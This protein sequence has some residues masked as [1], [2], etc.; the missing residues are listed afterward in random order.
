MTSIAV[1]VKEILGEINS[2]SVQHAIKPDDNLFE[3]GIL[4]SL[5]MV[6]FIVAVENRF[7]IKIANRDINY[8][9]FTTIGEI[10]KFLS[11]RVSK[12]E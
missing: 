4:D 12:N 1:Q 7:K 9:T 5:T 6:Q 10:E 8:E 11:T 2:T 3:M